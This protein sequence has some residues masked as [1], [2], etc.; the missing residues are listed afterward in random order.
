MSCFNLVNNWERISVKSLTISWCTGSVFSRLLDPQMTVNFWIVGKW[1]YSN[2]VIFILIIKII[3]FKICPNLIRI[4]LSDS[5]QII[6]QACAPHPFAL[7]D[8]ISPISIHIPHQHPHI[9]NLVEIPTFPPCA[10][11]PSSPR[12]SPGQPTCSCLQQK[13]PRPAPSYSATSPLPSCARRRSNRSVGTSKIIWVFSWRGSRG[14]WENHLKTWENHLK[15]WEH[16]LKTWDL[17]KRTRKCNHLYKLYFLFLEK[18]N[19]KWRCFWWEHD[20]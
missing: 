17:F 14:K 11:G 7:P 16:H 2:K 12:S 10:H 18:K 1:N 6:R 13:S 5:S 8:L 4:I 15:T 20:L 9:I 3:L 19:C